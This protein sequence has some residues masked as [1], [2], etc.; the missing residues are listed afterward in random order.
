M[1]KGGPLIPEILNDHV[2]L[3]L[4][5]AAESSTARVVGLDA[6]VLVLAWPTAESIRPP[7]TPVQVALETV[8]GTI[9]WDGVVAGTD[10]R[11]AS[12]IR[13]RVRLLGGPLRAE[14]RH[15]PR[16]PVDLPLEI[17]V[18]GEPA[19]PG[20]LIEVSC[21]SF[22]VKAR[23]DLL[24][25]DLA[26]VVIEMPDAAHL[27]LTASVVRNAG[28]HEAAMIYELIPRESRE[29]LVRY[30]FEQALVAGQHDL[31]QPGAA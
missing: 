4:P 11:D 28:R 14:R 9:W 21:E 12:S 26:S 30:A 22:K 1:V 25:G 3:L 19:V 6:D 10:D 2:R 7:A 16:A 24:A 20:R 18:A 27:R 8:H 5:D 13:V 29:A 17:A 23:I 31:A 15:S